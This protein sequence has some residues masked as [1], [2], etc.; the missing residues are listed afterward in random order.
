MR[1]PIMKIGPR[2]IGVS[3]MIGF[4][5]RIAHYIAKENAMNNLFWDS[6]LFD[7]ENNVISEEDR[8]Q[9]FKERLMSEGFIE[10]HDT[11]GLNRK[12]LRA[13][14]GITSELWKHHVNCIRN[15]LDG[16]SCSCSQTEY[17]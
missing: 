1:P 17:K 10:Q 3:E 12:E 5:A 4:A 7:S 9:A 6:S 11:H 14:G 13:N 15:M 2:N 16:Q 8:Y